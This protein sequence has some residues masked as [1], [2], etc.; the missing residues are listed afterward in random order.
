[1]TQNK[2]IGHPL[3]RVVCDAGFEPLLMALPIM[4]QSQNPA[5]KLFG[6]KSICI[7]S[8]I[9]YYPVSVAA[10]ANNKPNQSAI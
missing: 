1:M 9:A 7:V 4:R 6:A 10:D 2:P 3:A 8:G 5:L